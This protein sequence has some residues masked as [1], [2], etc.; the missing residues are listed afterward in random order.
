MNEKQRDERAVD[1]ITQQWKSM[2]TLPSLFKLICKHTRKL[3]T[4]E[5]RNVLIVLCERVQLEGPAYISSTGKNG[6]LYS[7]DLSIGLCKISDI[8]VLYL[9]RTCVGDEGKEDTKC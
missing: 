3:S 1:N 5:V 9:G 6:T 2:L 8:H 4:Q 7:L